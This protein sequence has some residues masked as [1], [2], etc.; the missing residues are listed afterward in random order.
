MA[1]RKERGRIGRT[2]YRTHCKCSILDK[3][4]NIVPKEYVI[5]GD[6]STRADALT[7][8]QK[9]FPGITI[10]VDEIEVTSFWASMP[11]EKFLQL[12]DITED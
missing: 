3:E 7:E 10:R 2:F 11:T 9:I 8:L 1:I 4:N 12:A 6:F 5:D